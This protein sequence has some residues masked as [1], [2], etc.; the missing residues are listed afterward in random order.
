MKT[1]IKVLLADDHN[2]VRNGI[3]SLFEKDDTNIKIIAEAANG[4]EVLEHLKAGINPDIII[5]D[6]NMPEM[7]GIELISIIKS[8]YPKIKILVL[9]ILDQESYVLQSL[10]AG[11]DGYLLKTVNISEIVFAIN[12]IVS[13]HKYICTNLTIQLL[14]KLKGKFKIGAA[15]LKSDVEISK[16]EVEILTLIAEGYTNSEIADKLFTSKRTI[17]GNRQN[18]LD[19]TGKRNTAALINFVVRNGIID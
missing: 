15:H 17:E 14:S 2:I 9:T 3:I 7:K 19:K 4:L 8:N 16:R 1:L 5:T 11:A 12:Q 6:I 10:E 13:G 18:L